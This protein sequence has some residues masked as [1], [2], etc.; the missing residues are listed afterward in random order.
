VSTD[1]VLGS[2]DDASAAPFECLLLLK[3]FLSFVEL[4]AVFSINDTAAATTVTESL[5]NALINFSANSFLLS[6]V[7]SDTLFN[8]LTNLLTSGS[9]SSTTDSSACSST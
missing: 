3:L 1:V 8:S 6:T 5:S 9:S 4:L 2:P 7:S